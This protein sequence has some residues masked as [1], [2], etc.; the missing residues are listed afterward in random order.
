M[1]VNVCVITYNHGKYISKCLSSMV[2]QKT[3]FDFKIIIRD[4][5][6]TDDTLEIIN[7]FKDK[8]PDL[9]EVL[10]SSENV[11]GAENS[12]LVFNAACLDYI[13]WCEGDDFF[14]DNFKLQKQFDYLEA[15]KNID[16]C[17][18]P[19]LVLSMKKEEISFLKEGKYFT[20]QDIL[21]TKGQF[22]AS[23]SYFFRTKVIKQLPS[24]F[25]DAPIGDSFFRI[26]CAKI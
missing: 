16:F 6:S 22:S 2:S 19:S 17:V 20:Q 8:Y 7:D 12:R 10:D 21:D 23:S 26:I 3:N 5:C 9:I 14:I 11:G 15:N 25:S 4:D 24:W 1:S 13:S 18:H